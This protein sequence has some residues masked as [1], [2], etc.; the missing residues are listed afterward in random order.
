MRCR[1]VPWGGLPPRGP[2]GDRVELFPYSLRRAK[3]SFLRFVTLDVYT[4]DDFAET[5]VWGS[6]QPTTCGVSCAHTPATCCMEYRAALPSETLLHFHATYP[7]RA[8][9]NR[10]FAFNGLLACTQELVSTLECVHSHVLIWMCTHLDVY[11]LVVLMCT[12]RPFN[13]YTH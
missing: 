6:L 9:P 11:S 5:C 8:M 4:F 10:D 13:V 12:H 2:W 1:C 7:T 3:S